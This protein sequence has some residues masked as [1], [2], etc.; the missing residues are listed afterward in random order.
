MNAIKYELN[1]DTKL[2]ERDVVHTEKD[3]YVVGFDKTDERGVKNQITVPKERV[4]MIY[5]NM[6]T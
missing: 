5:G 6:E 1:G 2:V 3:G 4:V